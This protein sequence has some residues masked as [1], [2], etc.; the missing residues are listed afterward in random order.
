MKKNIHTT[1]LIISIFFTQF[2]NAQ[3]SVEI[4]KRN[5]IYLIPTA[6]AGGMF[7][8]NSIWAV[9]GYQ[10]KIN[11][12][13]FIGISTGT[14]I[15]SEP[16]KSADIIGWASDKTTGYNVNIEHKLLLKKRFYYS[17]NLFYQNS[18]T[19]RSESIH[20]NT[21]THEY[22]VKRYVY[23]ITPKVGFVFI[24]KYHV[25]TDVGIGVG[26][27]HITSRT[28]NK[29]TPLSATDKEMFNGKTFEFGS[30]TLPNLLIQLKL[31]YNF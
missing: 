18:K 29:E 7:D 23:S 12:K 4:K 16:V 26:V 3:D 31:G 9:I 14:T 8:V 1:I 19:S 28:V 30:R 20:D 27:K 24:N 17:T 6:I 10:Y 22:Y 25:F 21:A 5:T 15:Y 2:L 13:C 11:K